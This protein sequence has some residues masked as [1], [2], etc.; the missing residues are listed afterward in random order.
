MLAGTHLYGAKEATLFKCEVVT[1]HG[2]FSRDGYAYFQL[3]DAFVEWIIDA[4]S[5][6]DL[7]RVALY[8]AADARPAVFY[9]NTEI[10]CVFEFAST[11]GW[12]L[13]N[14]ETKVTSLSPNKAAIM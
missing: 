7:E 13:W 5:T 4:P 3:F 2:G 9:V 12:A 6:G 8:L 14:S 10:V 11:C 1:M